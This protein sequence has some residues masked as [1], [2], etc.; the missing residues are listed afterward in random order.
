MADSDVEHRMD[1][2]VVVMFENRSFDNLL[3]YLY[4]P[5]EVPSFEGVGGRTLTNPIPKYAPDADRSIVAVH[6]AK[7][8]LA[9]DADPG[10]EYPH[11]NTQLYGTV[12][13]GDNQFKLPEAMQAPYNAPGD[14]SRNPTMDGFVTD[15]INTFRASV[16]R[17]PKYDEYAQI[18][19]CHTPAQL[20][21][22]SKLARSFACFDHWFCDVPSQT[23]TNRSFFHAG[24]ASGMVLNTPPGA[25]PLGNT[26]E[27]IFDRLE[28]ARVSWRVYFDPMQLVSAT[29]LIHAPR[30]KPYFATRFASIRQFY[31]D[32]K[33][34][35]LPAYAF[36]EP[37][38]I[39]PHTDMHPPGFASLRRFFLISPLS[40]ILGGERLL[41]GIY[42]AVRTS[43]TP[44]GS[45]F[46]NT[47]LLVTFDEHGGTYDHVPPPRVAPPDP[48]APV[49]QM[50][51]KFD[52]LGLR[53]PTLAISAWVDGRTVVSTEFRSTSVIRTL[54]ERW[55]LGGPLTQRDATAPDI[56]P[57]LTR[58]T[59]RA[60][61]E[62]PSVHAPSQPV[63]WM[64]ESVLAHGRPLAPL[65]MHL[66]G[67]AIAYEARETAHES[68]VEV[69]RVSPRKARR[70]VRR[71]R[72][73]TFPGATMYR[74]RPVR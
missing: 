35:T 23:Y 11:V 54:R 70:H 36:I 20:P 5:G 9:P 13:P 41:A 39:P 38:M 47:L 32:A 33:R 74:K 52:R 8:L 45:N 51:F 59:P 46:K 64:L 7:D 28:A 31:E 60:P 55:S 63:R 26:A 49:G 12:D 37:C 17:L 66:L 6:P 42:E 1:H 40:P 27:T 62:W 72:A 4:A 3:G 29:G 22:L 16:G 44:S 25:F 30:L 10:E 61:E 73:A 15:Y 53:V 50:G 34:G 57:I 58:E 65:G 56:G 2:I 69:D 67:A 19:G 71:L 18:M 24:T 21:V 43:S 68:V 14:P 48:S